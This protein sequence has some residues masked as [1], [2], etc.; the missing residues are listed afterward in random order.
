MLKL[1]A[2]FPGVCCHGYM[3]NIQVSWVKLG[4]EQSLGTPGSGRKLIS[5]GE[6][7]RLLTRRGVSSQSIKGEHS[8]CLPPVPV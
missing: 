6:G 8:F 5:G 2:V 7:H 1:E 4:F 3:A